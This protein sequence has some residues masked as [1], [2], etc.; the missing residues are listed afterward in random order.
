MKFSLSR[1]LCVCLAVLASIVP[2]YA[3]PSAPAPFSLDGIFNNKGELGLESVRNVALSQSTATPFYKSNGLETRFYEGD[4][5]AAADTSQLAILSDDGT[6]VWID[7]Q[8]IL[9]GA[10]K[11]QGFEN[12]D[13]TFHVLAKTFIKDRLYHL[14]LQYTNIVHR[15]NADVDG[16]S[17]WAYSGGGSIVPPKPLPPDIAIRAVD[18]DASALLGLGKHDASG[19]SQTKMGV[20]M[21]SVGRAYILKL[22]NTT[23][24]VQSLKLSAPA[25]ASGWTARFYDGRLADETKNVTNRAL[26]DGWPLELASGAEREVRVEMMPGATAT[27]TRLLPIT[28]ALASDADNKDVAR[29]EMTIQK[30]AKIQWS[31]DGTTWNDFAADAPPGIKHLATIG[32]R[33][34]KSVP[35]LEWPESRAIGPKWTWQGKSVHGETVWLQGENLTGEQGNLVEAELGNS[36]SQKVRV[37]PTYDTTLNVSEGVVLSGNGP[38]ALKTVT[39]T[40]VVA[41]DTD[42]TPKAGIKVRFRGLTSTGE[43]AGEVGTS[44]PSD[45]VAITD[46]LGVAQVTWTSG[47]SIGE[48]KLEAMTLDDKGRS[49]GKGDSITIQ[50]NA[51]YSRIKLGAWTQTN[52]AWSRSVTASAWFM[53]QKVPGCALTLS[54]QVRDYEAAQPLAGWQDCAPLDAAT[55]NTNAAGD[56]ATVQRWNPTEAGA[57]PHDYEVMAQAK[58]N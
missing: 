38:T 9:D 37:L 3:Q 2:G 17:L 18:E 26:Q 32:V 45:D 23:G 36:L 11:G 7:G 8:L 19:T 1:S 35:A 34:V 53:G 33:A 49:N 51:A 20:T 55:G 43:V 27:P 46:A 54:S 31:Y 56:F 30:I 13:S 29:I 28:L 4:F 21:M 16:L 57:W 40:A 5:K 48:V 22:C 50:S 14:R 44:L 39:L 52:G 47:A 10:D 12:F 58:V 15:D 25:D 42:D 41:D 24:N 6:S